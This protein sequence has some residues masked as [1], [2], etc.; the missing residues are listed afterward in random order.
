ME[1]ILEKYP[2]LHVWAVNIDNDHIH[3]QIEIPPNVPVCNVVQRIK[4]ISSIH[5]K[6]KFKFIDRMYIENN[7]WSVGY[8]S[9]TVGLNEQ[10]IKKYID[11]QG[12][13]DLPQQPGFEFD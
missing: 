1:K 12:K 7:I 8:F 3:M 4:Q 9:S 6:K 13:V 10:Q 11:N 2:T 5:L